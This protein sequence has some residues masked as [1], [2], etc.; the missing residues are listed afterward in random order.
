MAYPQISKA[1]EIQK[2]FQEKISK[3]KEVCFSRNVVYFDAQ[4]DLSFYFCR[5]WR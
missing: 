1:Y 3:R 2:T 5:L 4:K